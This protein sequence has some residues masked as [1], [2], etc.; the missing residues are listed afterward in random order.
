[1]KL[2]LPYAST[3]K[4]FQLMTAPELLVIVRLLPLLA[5]EALAAATVGIWMP[6]VGVICVGL[7][8][9]S[10]PPEV[11]TAPEPMVTVGVASDPPGTE[12]FGVNRLPRKHRLV[13]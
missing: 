1:M 4:L 12:V 11:I 13:P 2:V 8:S 10:E 3:E 9:D 6:P 7:C 5:K